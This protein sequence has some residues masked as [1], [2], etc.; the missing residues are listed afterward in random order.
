MDLCYVSR[1]NANYLLKLDEQMRKE[2]KSLAESVESGGNRILE[3]NPF[4]L[5]E[6]ARIMETYDRQKREQSKYLNTVIIEEMEQYK[7]FD[8]VTVIIGCKVKI[9]DDGEIEEYQ[10]LGTNEGDIYNKILS[11]NAPMSTE[12]IGRKVGDSF[13]FRGSI[14]KILEVSL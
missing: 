7:N 4:F 8:S 13:P 9:E 5:Q 6:R 1:A 11:C 2:L 3:E 12:L 10:I 14:I